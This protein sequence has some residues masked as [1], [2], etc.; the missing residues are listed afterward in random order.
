MLEAAW[1]AS[2]TPETFLEGGDGSLVPLESPVGFRI[3]HRKRSWFV[4]RKCGP[5]VCLSF[6]GL[7]MGWMLAAGR[8]AAQGRE[9]HRSLGLPGARGPFA[10]PFLYGGSHGAITGLIAIPCSPQ[11]CT[12]R[13]TEV[14]LLGSLQRACPAASPN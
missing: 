12:Y 2:L 13:A 3:F 5:S 7:L 8:G 6:P 11:P 4:P 10:C 1:E 9:S 14:Y